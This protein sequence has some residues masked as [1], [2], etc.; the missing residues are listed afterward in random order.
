MINVIISY[1]IILAGAILIFHG[2]RNTGKKAMKLDYRG[3]KVL[4][5]YFQ[6]MKQVDIATGTSS[7]LLGA[8]VLLNLVTGE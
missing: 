2:I 8:S 5:K 7:V 6:Y 4:E 1:I 3:N